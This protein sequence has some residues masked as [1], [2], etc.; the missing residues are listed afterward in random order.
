MGVAAVNV[1]YFFDGSH[2]AQHPLSGG[3][4]APVAPGPQSARTADPAGMA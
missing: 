3:R 1:Y 2:T 4:A